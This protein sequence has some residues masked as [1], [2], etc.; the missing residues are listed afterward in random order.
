MIADLPRSITAVSA[1]AVLLLSSCE[2]Q[3]RGQATP[4]AAEQ[5]AQIAGTITPAAL[6]EWETEQLDSI[7]K[8]IRHFAETAD[9]RYALPPEEG[10]YTMLHLACYFK[11]PELARCLLLDG[12]DPNA[13]AMDKDM[14]GNPVPGDIPLSFA[15]T[16]YGTEP[17][18]QAILQ[19][20]DILVK[21]GADLSK[22]GP[23][24]ASLFVPALAQSSEEVFLKFLKLGAPLPATFNA[25]GY[26]VPIAAGPAMRGWLTAMQRVIEEREK[27]SDTDMALQ[28]VLRYAVLGCTENTEACVSY[29]LGRGADVNQISE[30]GYTPL[31]AASRL[32]Y[33][34][35]H[36]MGALTDD[37]GTKTHHLERVITL[38]LTNGADP[39]IRRPDD[40]TREY[41]GFCAADFL[42]N[43]PDFVEQLKKAG[44]T[45]PEQDPN[46][47]TG[48]PLLSEICRRTMNPDFKL[49]EQDYDA[50][51]A[52][53]NPTPEMRN[54][55]LYEMALP[56]AIG[57]LADL[58]SARTVN[59]LTGLALWHHTHP[60]TDACDCGNYHAILVQ[61][62]NEHPRLVMPAAF[63]I[64]EAER[65]LN[66][67]EDE[68][69]A[70]LVELLYRCPDADQQI[71][72]LL[73][74]PRLAVQA[75]A[76]GAKL[77][78]MGLPAPRAES[79]KEWLTAHHREADTPILRKALRL[80]SLEDFWYGR[81]DK[82]QLA[83]FLQDIRDI[84]APQAHALY[85][86]LAQNLDQPEKLDEIST[87]I[88]DA[89]YELEIATARFIHQNASAFTTPGTA[90]QTP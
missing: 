64:N 83:Q 49:R 57:L 31:Y 16:E 66:L 13:R 34:L 54:S 10:G 5:F 17:D 70:N 51:A 23:G 80:T 50:V 73:Q 24:G 81:M 87:E 65:S 38:L 74:D 63:L 19:L 42:T 68:L 25:L 88:G 67:G 85:Q 36:G 21:G 69:A 1:A 40:D 58:D 86:K 26:N 71:S 2:P 37:V 77:R 61:A 82:A 6:P 46:F 79:V 32:Y 84:G 22:T 35:R 75:G 18:T 62:I 48:I 41:P 3:S 55:E 4:E 45:L 20:L 9:A 78:S 30:D 76:W 53:L 39:M 59:L 15:L 56:K 90:P 11:K 60:H 52:V 27:Q 43:S 72:P 29:L 47:T 8:L 28:H 44:I 14:D 33:E 12:A 7:S 89:T